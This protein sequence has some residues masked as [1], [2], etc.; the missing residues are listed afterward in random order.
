MWATAVSGSSSDTPRGQSPL[1]ATEDFSLVLGGPLYHLL[2]SA[3]LSDDLLAHVYRRI[4]VATA[5]TW[6]PLLL[7]SLWKGQAWGGD[8]QIPFALSVET[9]ARYLVALPLLLLAELIVHVR[10]GQLVQ[11]FLGRKLIA[12]ADRPRFDAAI[13][14]AMR[15]RNSLTAELLLLVMVFGLGFVWRD[16]LAVDASTWASDA[17]AVSG[18]G[19]YNLSPAGWWEALVSLPLFQFLQIRWYFRLFI[20]TRFLTQVSRINLQLMPMH[21]DRAGGLG[22]LATTTHAFTPLLTAHGVLLAGFIADRIFFGGAQLQQFV[23]EI[24]G[25]AC[26]LVLLVLAPLMPLSGQLLRAKRSGQNQFGIL[27]Q[28]YAR[29]FDAKWLRG[30]EAPDEPLVGSADI[31]SLADLG[32]SYEVIRDM[33]YVPFSKDTAIQLAIAT[34]APILPLTL[35]MISLEEL[36]KRLVTAVF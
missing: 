27:A 26:F 34:V 16:Y 19:R 36:L 5:I 12:D 22:F 7:L 33:R 18:S 24:A 8:I 14:S 21:P 31:Q 25:A 9:H 20:W 35:T 29:E 28:R 32:N 15:L 2:R 11:Q 1:K 3:G 10:M 30:S 4:V 23:L 6:M 17:A 13:Q